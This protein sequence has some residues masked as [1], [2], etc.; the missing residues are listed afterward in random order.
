V[1]K[2]LLSLTLLVNITIALAQDGSVRNIHVY[3]P[4]FKTYNVDSI[5]TGKVAGINFDSNP[6]FKLFRTAIRQG[7]KNNKLNFAGHYCFVWWGC[8][9]PCQQSA[10][11]DLKTGRIYDT[12][13]GGSGYE[14]RKDSR[15]VVVN[16]P[17]KNNLIY[18]YAIATKPEV[19]V[20]NE[21]TKKFV[22]KKIR[23]YPKLHQGPRED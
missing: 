10:I 19:W 8:G 1:K 15:M 17:P 14:F 16:P 23:F 6:Q 3:L 18:D 9:S 13:S 4:A 2:F 20:L 22:Q 5:Y 21:Q 7:Y 11:V 12:L